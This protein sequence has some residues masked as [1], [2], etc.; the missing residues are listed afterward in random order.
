[1]YL[2]ISMCPVTAAVS[3]ALEWISPERLACCFGAD[4]NTRGISEQWMMGDA[5]LVSPI[6]YQGATSA[7][8]Y[9]PQGTWYDSLS[10]TIA[11]LAARSLLENASFG[12]DCNSEGP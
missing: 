1:M 5:L 6:L 3:V 12:G 11:W 8:A 4:N 9:F 2:L 7:R 10:S